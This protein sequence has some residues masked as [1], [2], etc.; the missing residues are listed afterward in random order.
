[1][2]MGLKEKNKGIIKIKKTFGTASF[3][4]STKEMLKESDKEDWSR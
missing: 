1:M 2:F 3:K 4:R